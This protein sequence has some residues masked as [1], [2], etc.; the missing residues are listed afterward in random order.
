MHLTESF[1][2]AI[3][4][5]SANKLRTILTMVGIII[6]NASVITMIGIG[7]G[8]QRLADKEFAS[9]GPNVLFVVPGNDD[10]RRISFEIPDTLVLEDAWAIRDQVPTVLDVAPQ[11]SGLG[12]VVYRNNNLST[13]LFGTTPS[14]PSVRSFELAQGRFLTDADLQRRERVAVVGCYITE[15]LLNLQP[16][17]ADRLGAVQG[18]ICDKLS[19]NKPLLPSETLVGQQIRIQNLTFQVIG[20]TRPKGSFAGTN[21]DDVI[22]IPLTTMADRIVGKT[23]LGAGT[24]VSFI[25]IAAQETQSK[26]AEFQITNLLRQRHN[27]TGSND[28]EVRSQEDILETVG[29]ITGALT[30]LLAGI[31]GISLF[32]GG[33]G[34]MNIMLVSVSERTQ[35]IG[36]RKAIGANQGDILLQFLI[37]AIIVS[38]LGGAIGTAIGISAIL[39]LGSTTALITQISGTVI[40]ISISISGSI[41]L[42]FGVIPARQAAQLDPIVALR[43]H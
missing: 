41:G 9:L 39:L 28:F 24:E 18:G 29:N 16:G 40:L 38:A 17:D 32:V 14:F 37:E 20:M 19:D 3:A 4:A 23:N 6:G 25:S 43:S 5:L 35:E 8:V 27:I 34:I 2:M 21:Q 31:A 13:Q 42:G 10:T 33:I 26:A 1:Q 15:Q 7:Q 30:I 12:T 36:L 11:I 22:F